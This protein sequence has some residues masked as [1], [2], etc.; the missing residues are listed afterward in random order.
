MNSSTRTELLAAIVAMTRHQPLI[1][2]TDCAA[3]VSRGGRLIRIF[4]EAED[5]T[6]W[7]DLKHPWGRPWSQLIDGDFWKLSWK[8]IRSRGPHMTRLQKVKGHLTD[9]EIEEGLGTLVE[10]TGNDHADRLASMGSDATVGGLAKLLEFLAARHQSYCKFM[11]RVRKF[12][13]QMKLAET[14]LR[15][16]AAKRMDPFGKGTKVTIS[17]VLCEG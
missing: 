15:E 14:K 6:V 5:G 1:I 13:G 12:I 10:Q 2:A 17:P 7:D 4:E 8:A 11:A 16:E 9:K 3:L